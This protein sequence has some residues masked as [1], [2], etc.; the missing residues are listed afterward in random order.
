MKI[1]PNVDPRSGNFEV[2]TLQDFKWY[3]FIRYLH[4]L[5]NGTHLSVKNVSSIRRE[6]NDFVGCYVARDSN[7]N[8]SNSNISSVESCCGGSRDKEICDLHPEESIAE[9]MHNLELHTYRCTLEELYAFVPLSW[10]KEGLLTNLR[11]T[12]HISND[13]HLMELKNLISGGDSLCSITIVP[14]DYVVK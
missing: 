3:H 11:I 6:L 2:V 12:L 10:E 5:Y 8:D 1:T 4:R 13:E 9:S 7:S 14:V